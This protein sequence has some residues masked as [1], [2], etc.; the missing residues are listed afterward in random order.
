MTPKENNPGITRQQHA[1]FVAHAI[2]IVSLS[3][4]IPPSDILCQSR[5]RE[6]T[7]AR[8]L[9]IYAARRVLNMS[10]PRLGKAFGRHATCAMHAVK[11]VEDRIAKIIGAA[12]MVDGICAR[13]E[14]FAPKPMHNL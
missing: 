4:G 12:E 13:L 8:H 11:A 6:P 7:E 1:E 2:H 10:Y 5:K 9:A 3:T 14:R